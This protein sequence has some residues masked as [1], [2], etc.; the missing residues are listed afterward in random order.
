[1]VSWKIISATALLLASTFVNADDDSKKCGPGS[2]C[3][4]D[5]P[6]CNAYGECGTGIHCLGGCD[7]RYS[8]KLDAC[9][10]MPAC[11]SG[12]TYFNETDVVTNQDKY[13]GDADKDPWTYTGN[14][15]A[16]KKDDS[17]LLTMKKESTGTV[18][19]ASNYIWYG[20][21]KVSM[22][23]SHLQGVITNFILMSDVKDEI[24]Y[25]FVGNDLDHAQTNYYFQGYTDYT[26]MK[27]GDVDNSF[28]S[29]H[30]YEVDWSEDKIDWIID[31]ETVRTVKKD[32]T[33]NET[34]KNYDFPQTPSRIQIALWPGGDKSQGKGTIEWAGGEIDWDADDIKKQGYYYAAL[35]SV[36]VECYDKPSGAKGNGTKAYVYNDKTGKK[37]NVELSGKDTKL[38]DKDN[39]GIENPKKSFADA[40]QVSTKTKSMADASEVKSK[41]KKGSANKTQG[42]KG[43]SSSAKSTDDSGG[44]SQ[45]GDD[46]DSDS[47][48]SDDS[49]SS[50]SSESSSSGNDSS[51]APIVFVSS[52][53]LALVAGA[54]V[55]FM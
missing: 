10:P 39:S 32:D 17:L 35:K 9:M 24:D 4:K 50:D 15:L 30:D 40:S 19:S 1:M 18:I 14:V 25:E 54:A 31:G 11:K 27:K 29:Y 3:P 6:C 8:F 28:E 45:G 47:S 41:T 33:Y 21:I 12:T 48:S 37:D 38:N 49:K 2:N 7:P 52:S 34:T 44:F 53:I 23:T 55:V 22:K 20:K 26:K 36:E 13:L 51:S 43:G 5:K 16:Y 42:S 46:D